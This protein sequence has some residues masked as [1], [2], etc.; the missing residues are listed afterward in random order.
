MYYYFG[1]N[2]MLHQEHLAKLFHSPK[3]FLPKEYHQ[4]SKV[5][6]ASKM[7]AS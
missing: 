7:S 2:P 6:K 5:Y 3:K 1:S 4:Q